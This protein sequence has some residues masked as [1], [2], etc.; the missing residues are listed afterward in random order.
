MKLLLENWRK[1]LN[2][3]KSDIQ[4]QKI[5]DFFL[6]LIQQEGLWEHFKSATAQAY[7]STS[8]S[9]RPGYMFRLT[10]GGVNESLFAEYG[11]MTGDE[12]IISNFEIFKTVFSKFKILVIPEMDEYGT[13]GAAKNFPEKRWGF[14]TLTLNADYIIPGLGTY[15]FLTD[16]PEVYDEAAPK[17]IFKYVEEASPY[18]R[19]IINHEITHYL[20]FI[21]ARFGNVA[22]RAVISRTSNPSTA[23]SANS[24][25]E[26]QAR[27]IAA[28]KIF[29]EVSDEYK[30]GSFMKMSPQEFLKLFIVY[31]NEPV[32][33]QWGR[34][35]RNRQIDWWAPI[36]PKLK[37][38]VMARI[39]DTENGVFVNLKRQWEKD[40][41]DA[42]TG[43][44]AGTTQ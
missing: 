9:E 26:I 2:E 34:T 16:K 6:Y 3:R 44:S 4:Y 43:T 11:E 35:L 42:P 27:M 37:Q 13:F 22:G 19:R 38:K 41:L 5:T 14:A 17:E 40:N 20:T 10:K 36:E 18:I 25:D 33:P 15:P 39:F 24:T 30:D 1:Y 32:D 31:Y 7:L 23:Q 12:D 8:R 28:I 29:K 21:R